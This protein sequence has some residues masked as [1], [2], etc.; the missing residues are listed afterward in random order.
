MLSYRSVALIGLSALACAQPAKVAQQRE[1]T[2]KNTNIVGA[3]GELAVWD[4]GRSRGLPLLFLHADSG[5]ASQWREVAS[6][7]SQERRA[8]SFDF[9][10]SGDSAPA[11]DG[12]YSYRGRADDVAAVADALGLQKLVIVAHSGGAAVALEYAAQHAPRVAGLLLVDPPTDPRALPQPVRDGFVRDL[13]GPRSL[14]VQQDFYRTIAGDNPATRQRVLADCES[15]VPAARAGIGLS[16]A[17]WDPEPAL[18]AW[19]GPTLVLVT[20]PNDNQHALYHLNENL[21]HRVVGGSGHWL[22]L[23]QPG[24][25]AETV[26]NFVSELEA[27]SP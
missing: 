14:Q 10:G 19:H 26:R 4:T 3:Q 7:L 15:V 9:R 23:D 25:V 13:A 8:I 24:V 27:K 16:F 12:D 6:E 22:Q 21:P 17:T 11:R 5:R 1:V 2:V 18:R 20:P